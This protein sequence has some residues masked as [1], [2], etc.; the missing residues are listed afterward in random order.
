MTEFDIYT[1]N[2]KYVILSS[3]DV[4]DIIKKS[5]FLVVLVNYDSQPYNHA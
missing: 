3:S 4:L 2:V 1:I 5:N